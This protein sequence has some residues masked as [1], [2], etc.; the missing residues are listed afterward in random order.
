METTSEAG[1]EESWTSVAALLGPGDPPSHGI[2]ATF[3]LTLIPARFIAPR[4][5]SPAVESGSG[6][7]TCRLAEPPRGIRPLTRRTL[8]PGARGN[9]SS[10]GAGEGA[11]DTSALILLGVGGG[12]KESGTPAAA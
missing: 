2:T 10:G 3:P 4:S 9:A 5:T 12:S 11:I 1:G 8:E 7:A 6:T